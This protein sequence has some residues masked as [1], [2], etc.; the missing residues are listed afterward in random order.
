MDPL[1]LQAPYC[2]ILSV[3]C[4]KV[5]KTLEIFSIFIIDIGQTVDELLEAQLQALSKSLG[6]KYNHMCNNKHLI[7]IQVFLVIITESDTYE[8]K[9]TYVQ[10]PN[11][12]VQI[13]DNP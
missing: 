3:N 10:N 4:T 1:L 12:I 2:L 5:V 11:V 6:I 7:F 9:C 8:V 13:S